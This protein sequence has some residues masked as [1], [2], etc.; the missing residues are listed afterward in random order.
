MLGTR[1]TFV[2]VL[3]VVVSLAISSARAQTA[4]PAIA[5]APLQTNPIPGV[6]PGG[7]PNITPP[8]ATP[9]APLGA[10]D[11]RSVQVE[12]VEIDGVTVYSTEQTQEL[13]AALHTGTVTVGQISEAAQALQVRY[14]D[15]GYVLTKVTASLAPKDGGVVVKVSVV[16]GYIASVKL[17]GDVGPVGNL[18][19]RE[20]AH[21]LDIRPVRLQDIER[22][23]LLVQDLPGITVHTVLQAMPADPGAVEM[24]AQVERKPFDASFSDDNR[25]SKPLGP[26]ELLVGA[27]ANSFSELGDRTELTIFNT[28]FDNEETYGQASFDGHIGGEGTKFHGYIGYGVIEPG[29]TLR[30]LGYKTRLFQT[31]IGIEYPLVRTRA[32]S[33]FLD[34]NFDVSNSVID[35]FDFHPGEGFQLSRS[36]LRVFR[37]GETTLFQDMIFGEALPAANSI[38]ITVHHGA[39][40]FFN[41]TRD[42]SNSPSVFGEADDFTKLTFE[43][44]RNQSIAT[45]GTTDLRLFLA[46]KGQWTGDILPTAEKMLLGGGEYGRGFY[47]GEVTG[48]RA[49]AGTI[50]LRFDQRTDLTLPDESTGISLQYY[51]FFDGGQTWSTSGDTDHSIESVGLGVRTQLTSNVSLQVEEAERLTRRPTGSDTDREPRHAVFFRLAGS[52]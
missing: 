12:S 1:S 21:L 44:M 4:P 24:I 41:G 9:N 22:Y 23:A 6:T 8:A 48:D 47:S 45:W 34:G 27:A 50:E 5:P 52:F 39:P 42:G 15:D 25:G 38:N 33:L 43:A 35:L 46:A 10:E 16:E 37:F 40:N 51:G 30:S 17:D 11:G 13:F 32:W 19:Y 49:I 20:L 7:T 31:G 29:Y 3:G 28:P 36:D 18:I 14:R 26:N 2:G